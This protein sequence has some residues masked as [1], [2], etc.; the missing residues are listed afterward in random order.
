MSW[1]LFKALE[2]LNKNAG[3]VPTRACATK[4]RSAIEEGFNGRGLTRPPL[5][6]NV[7]DVCAKDYGPSLKH[8]G[9]RELPQGTRHY[10]AGDVVIFEG[11]QHHEAGHM[12]MFNGR[13]WVSDYRQHFDVLPTAAW[14]GTTFPTAASAC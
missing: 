8:A 2:H 7:N 14:R 3:P 4:V 1:Y 9:F 12:A 11:S 10:E 13:I 5:D 6:P